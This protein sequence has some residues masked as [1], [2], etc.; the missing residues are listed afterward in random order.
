[1]KR[2]LSIFLI[3]TIFSGLVFAD[4]YDEGDEYDDGYVYETNGA[5]DQ[6]FKFG[7]GTIIPVNFGGA[8]KQDG[9]YAN[10]KLY[11]GGNIN[12]GYYRFLNNWLAVGGEALITYN[13][14]V[15]N[16]ILVMLPVTFGAMAMPTVGNFEFPCFLT[17]GVSYE[18]WQNNHNFPSP[19]VNASAGV[20]Y[21]FTESFSL[22]ATATML[23]TLQF[24]KGKNPENGLFTTANIALRYHF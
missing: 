15:G 19:A 21:R 11:T 12:L 20:F 10:G 1:M 6:F 9:T 3:L 14:S 22:G 17:A 16:K 4:A 5:G 2:F 23:Y 13:L 7:I 24:V 18:T 8:V